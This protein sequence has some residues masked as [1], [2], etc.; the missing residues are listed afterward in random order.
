[1]PPAWMLPPDA[2]RRR[3]NLAFGS[4]QYV[5]LAEAWNRA[6]VNLPQRVVERIIPSSQYAAWPRKGTH[7]PVSSTTL[8][9]LGL[10]R[11][12]GWSSLTRSERE[13]VANALRAQGMVVENLAGGEWRPGQRLQKHLH[14]GVSRAEVVARGLRP[15]L[16]ELGRKAARRGR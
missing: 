9:L 1:M 12:A 4:D 11:D 13:L 5:R 8:H 14:F 6:T 2:I 7:G 16:E 15:L 10:A 3:V